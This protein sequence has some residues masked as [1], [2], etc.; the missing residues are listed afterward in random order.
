M[1]VLAVHWSYSQTNCPPASIFQLD[2]VG[3]TYRLERMIGTVHIR[4]D[5]IY[6]TG[7]IRSPRGFTP[8]YDFPVL[9][10]RSS[11]GRHD[12]VIITYFIEMR[13]FR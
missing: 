12:I 7:L 11:F 5:R 10:A 2:E 6:R 9:V 8:L 13:S 4:Q 3:M 1:L